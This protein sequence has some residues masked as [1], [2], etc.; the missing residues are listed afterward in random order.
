MIDSPV[1]VVINMS[2]DSS[3]IGMQQIFEFEQMLMFVL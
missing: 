1:K 3:G 2:L